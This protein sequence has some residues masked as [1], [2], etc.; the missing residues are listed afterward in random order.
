MGY[1][2]A[3]H[4]STWWIEAGGVRLQ[5]PPQLQSKA[6]IGLMRYYLQKQKEIQKVVHSCIYFHYNCQMSLYTSHQKQHIVWAWKLTP[7]NTAVRRQRRADLCESE[8]SLHGK[9]QA[10]AT[11]KDPEWVMFQKTKNKK[12]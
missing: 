4:P 7:V 5:G 10:R 3:Y 11:Q 1:G 12:P 9:F 8:A 6:N 2:C